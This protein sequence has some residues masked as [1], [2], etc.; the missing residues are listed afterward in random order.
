M[1]AAA[2]LVSY[3]TGGAQVTRQVS[4]Y[5]FKVSSW[6]SET[7][8]IV[9]P[10][11]NHP[12]KPKNRLADYHPLGGCGVLISVQIYILTIYVHIGVLNSGRHDSPHIR[13]SSLDHDS[14]EK[15]RGCQS[16]F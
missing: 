14:G 12:Q 11:E 16:Y 7:F 6:G 8:K 15:N 1:L 4:Q 2:C 10:V 13:K 3:R 9:I 5:G